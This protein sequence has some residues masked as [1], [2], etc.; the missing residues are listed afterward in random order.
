MDIDILNTRHGTQGEHDK[1]FFPTWRLKIGMVQD[2][3]APMPVFGQLTF[4]V[5]LRD[6]NMSGMVF[7]GSAI[8]F[9]VYMI[10]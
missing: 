8:V 6:D 7:L 5:V 3:M 10:I 9:V 4:P 2:D 1:K